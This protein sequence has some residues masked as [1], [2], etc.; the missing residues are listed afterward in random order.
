ML[1]LSLPHATKQ[2]ANINVT[3]LLRMF[4]AL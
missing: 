1:G 2:Q 4:R 3:T